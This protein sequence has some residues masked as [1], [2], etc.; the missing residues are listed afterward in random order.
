MTTA[1]EAP[2][3][4]VARR[5][6]SRSAVSRRL[7]PPLCFAAGLLVAWQV[8]CTVFAVPDYLVPT[9]TAVA[10]AMHANAG[11]L[12]N[13]AWPTLLEALLGFAIGNL[14]A[15]ALAVV[16]VHWRGAERACMPVAV[17]IQTI[18]VVAIAPVLVILMGNGYA[19]KIAIAAIIS[20]FP[21]LVNMVKGLQA[22]SSESLELLRVL[23][24]SRWEVFWKVRIFASLP[25]LFA[26]L[27]IA[28]TASMIGAIIAEWIGSQAGLGYL[29]IQS[30]Y[31]F[32]TSLLY[33]TMATSSILAVAFFTVIGVLESL[34]IRWEP[35][36]VS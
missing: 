22:V 2:R 18:P 30:T 13:N 24:A 11:L 20:F 27:K 21:T 15:I 36:R 31:N 19:P 32:N 26:S 4:L 33:A 23:S 17:F 8:V 7:L 9:P 10:G 14:V 28:V 29:I 12:A 1:V 6:R 3:R 35:A 5:S 25:Y 16:F 34:L